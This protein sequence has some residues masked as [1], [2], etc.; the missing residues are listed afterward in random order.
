MKKQILLAVLAL[1]PDFSLLGRNSAPSVYVHA[2]KIQ[3]MMTEYT[4]YSL[5]EKVIKLQER[6][7]EVILFTASPNVLEQDLKLAIFIMEDN[8]R[9][10]DSIEAEIDDE[11]A[12][13]NRVLASMNPVRL[14]Y[15][16]MATL[17]KTYIKLGQPSLAMPLLEVACPVLLDKSRVQNYWADEVQEWVECYLSLEEMYR[18]Q[19][20]LEAAARLENTLI[21]KAPWLY[22]PASNPGNKQSS[23]TPITYLSEE[24]REGASTAWQQLGVLRAAMGAYVAEI[25]GATSVARRRKVKRRALSLAAAMKHGITLRSYEASGRSLDEEELKSTEGLT[26]LYGPVGGVLMMEVLKEAGHYISIMGTIID[27]GWNALEEEVG[28]VEELDLAYPDSN[29]KNFHTREEVLKVFINH[30]KEAA[31]KQ[32]NRSKVNR[33]KRAKALEDDV[34]AKK[35]EEVHV[36]TQLISEQRSKTKNNGGSNGWLGWCTST[37]FLSSALVL[38]LV[39]R[40]LTLALRA[41]RCGGSTPAAAL[42]KLTG[43][44]KTPREGNAL[45]KRAVSLAARNRGE[46]LGDALSEWQV[47]CRRRKAYRM[48]RRIAS[49]MSAFGANLCGTVKSSAQRVVLINYWAISK[50][51]V[52]LITEINLKEVVVSLGRNFALPAAS[53]DAETDK[54]APRSRGKQKRKSKAT[55]KKKTP[56]K[57]VEAQKSLNVVETQEKLEGSSSSSEVENNDMVSADSSS[58]FA[59]AQSCESDSA[60]EETEDRNTEVSH[61][62]DAE[63]NGT[64]ANKE[65]ESK[66]SEIGVSPSQDTSHIFNLHSS[67]NS[68]EHK[69]KCLKTQKKA[70]SMEKEHNSHSTNRKKAPNLKKTSQT[71]TQT[72]TENNTSCQHKIMDFME[73]SPLCY[74]TKNFHGLMLKLSA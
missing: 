15:T 23:G 51:A 10:W 62:H 21:A 27:Y 22:A 69:C 52:L 68:S 55:G 33:A 37:A 3:R 74:T 1:N 53:S 31:Q 67:T 36:D 39:A 35:R 65:S 28:L 13:G 5:V 46:D 64:I 20:K 59:S 4:D 54:K 40:V 26:S 18:Q 60:L 12:Q 24:A 70:R 45:R 9:E 29:A 32:A 19:G 47:A 34:K 56:N 42:M 2:L 44:P 71:Q 49:G 48:L 73:I 17:A 38:G 6:Y 58:D 72:Q 8:L 57:R 63:V 50:N 16:N 30:F 61:G 11:I 14:A 41:L 66:K 43:G 7:N 25:A